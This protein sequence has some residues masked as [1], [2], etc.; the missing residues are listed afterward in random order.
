[1]SSSQ[2]LVLLVL[3]ISC[4]SFSHAVDATSNGRQIE[5]SLLRKDSDGR[6]TQ[7]SPWGD[8]R[9]CVGDGYELQ[10]RIDV[11][12]STNFTVIKISRYPFDLDI[13]H[14]N[15]TNKWIALTC[16]K[17]GGE[18]CSIDGQNQHAFIVGINSRIRL[19]KIDFFNGKGPYGC[20]SSGCR[21][22]GAIDLVNSTLSMTYSSI[23]NSN[24]GSLHVSGDYSDINSTTTANVYLDN[25]L[26]RDNTDNGVSLNNRV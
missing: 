15:I 26:F 18:R 16:G 3:F 10:R 7:H 4:C 19:N 9:G 14:I 12:N 11:A 6:R 22:Y 1:M 24:G 5:S 20:F 8:C 13:G 21:N 17:G 23:Q 25:V 2:F